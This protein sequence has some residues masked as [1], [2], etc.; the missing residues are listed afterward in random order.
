MQSLPLRRSCLLALPALAL[1]SGCLDD[2]PDAGDVETSVAEIKNLNPYVNA[3]AG[4]FELDMPGGRLNKVPVQGN[5]WY[6]QFTYSIGG[7]GTRRLHFRARC[8]NASAPADECDPALIVKE[9]IAVFP[10]TNT[11]VRLVTPRNGQAYGYVDYVAGTVPRTITVVAFSRGRGTAR[12]NIQWDDTTVSGTPDWD[13]SH[14][15]TDAATGAALSGTNKIVG[16]TMVR[17]GPVT[18]GDVF[19]VRTPTSGSALIDRTRMWMV[20]PNRKQLTF[21]DGA[22]TGDHDPSFTFT[23]AWTRSST[24]GGMSEVYALVARDIAATGPGGGAESFVQL[25]RGTSVGPGTTDTPVDFGWASCTSANESRPDCIDTAPATALPP[26]RYL[27]SIWASTSHPVANVPD[28]Y[29]YANNANRMDTGAPWIERGQPNDLALRLDL[30]REDGVIVEKRNVPRAVL[31]TSAPER[32]RITLELMVPDD[33]VNHSYRLNIRDLGNDVT[34]RPKWA[35]RRDFEAVELKV[36]TANI[37]YEGVDM[38]TEN[39]F[40]NIADRIDRGRVSS[41]S[42]LLALGSRHPELQ[43]GRAG[44]RAGN[45]DAE[46]ARGCRQ[47][48]VELIG[49]HQR[50]WRWRAGAGWQQPGTPWPGPDQPARDTARGDGRRQCEVRRRSAQFC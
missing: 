49:R 10:P 12:V 1:V 26:G 9:N 44:Q 48:A 15:W 13:A 7:S 40:K 37:E 17:L 47:P 32:S 6:G 38:Q 30:I 22:T 24:I 5:V 34:V 20:N 50:P 21:V 8:V 43:R 41:Q 18:A 45:H 2:D 11:S 3:Q 46:Q 35:Y 31:G 25:T 33:G 39:E 23:S 36:A 27:I 42:G 29:G 4:A 19:A 14:T 16:G 28:V